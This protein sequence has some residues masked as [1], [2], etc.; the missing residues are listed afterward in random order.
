MNT[1]LTQGGSSAAS[2]KLLGL[3][4]ESAAL[5]AV[6][7]AFVI[8]RLLLLLVIWLSMATIPMRPG[9]WLYA[10][11]D[12]LPLDGLI[13]FDSWWYHN[14]ITSGYR[15]GD[16]SA[17]IQ[18]NVAFFPLYPVVVGMASVLTGDVFVAGVLV[19]HLA[20][21]V[22]LCYIY[23]LTRREF[24]ADAAGRAVFYI[25]AAPT[26]VFFSA[27]YTESL[28]VALVAATFYYAR[29]G[30]WDRAALAGALAA[31]T[32]NTGVILAAVIVLEGLHQQGFRFWPAGWRWA[33]LRQNGLPGA[34]AAGFAHLKAQIKWILPAWPSLVA[35]CTVPLGL[36]AYMG[37]LAS[38]FGDPLAFINSQAAWGRNT[39]PTAITQ[40]S[41]NALSSLAAG[42]VW[43]GQF[44][45]Q[46][47]LEMLTVAMVIPLVIG[48]ALRLRPAHLLFVG[49]TFFV[50]L[51]TGTTGSV[52][53]YLL[54][55][56]PCFMLLGLWG[57]KPWV[58]RLVLGI[59]LPLMAYSAV[60]FSHWYFAG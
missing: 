25:A 55:L 54:M 21:F 23:G 28:F 38:R 7:S 8:T 9:Q 10:S 59:S 57:Q 3:T 4:V 18:G 39:S 27:M 30:Q 48:V 40:L 51:S 2:F 14:I 56:V 20:F 45:G 11:P 15:L 16:V 5:R 41:G 43:L 34:V 42:N 33:Q 17:G 58:E 37:Y 24:G 53:R 32:R 13:R 12:N 52:N 46:V 44:N 49:L 31:A 19:S 22:A 29:N 60:L 35:G 1:T 47:F 50:P 6:L 26:A 36:L